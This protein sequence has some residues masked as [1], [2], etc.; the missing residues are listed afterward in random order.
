[1]NANRQSPGQSHYLG[2]EPILGT[3]TDWVT[4]YRQAFSARAELNE[5][6][7]DEVARIAHDLNV[8]PRELAALVGKGPNS[9]ALLDKMLTALG[10]D[11]ENKYIKDLR[12]VRDLQRLCFGCD[13]K[14]QCAHAL[15]AGTA[16]EHYREF[17]PNAYT[18]DVIIGRPQ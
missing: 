8:S 5:V 16:K 10:V 15:A 7:S 9:A 3:I 6:G 18:L 14:R 13:H 4:R 2:F 1:M 11:R 12:L 17:C